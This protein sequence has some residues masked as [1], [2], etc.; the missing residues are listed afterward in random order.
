M[1]KAVF[2]IVKNQNQADQISN[3]LQHAGFPKQEISVISPQTSANYQ[4][5]NTPGQNPNAPQK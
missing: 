5:S 1:K 4:P 3:E 2:C